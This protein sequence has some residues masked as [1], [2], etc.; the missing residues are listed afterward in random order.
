MDKEDLIDRANKEYE[1]LCKQVDFIDQPKFITFTLPTSRLY[2]EVTVIIKYSRIYE[3][4]VKY[5]P[6]NIQQTIRP[7]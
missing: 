7:E 2:M 1:L 4:L 3:I 5:K 6:D